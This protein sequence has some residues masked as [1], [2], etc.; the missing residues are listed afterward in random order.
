MEL[1]I[2]MARSETSA[3][4]APRGSRVVSQ[5][6]F[7]ALDA[8]PEA[9]QVAVAR[10]AQIMIRDQLKGRRENA[11]RAATKRSPAGLTHRAKP[12]ATA[13]RRAKAA[14]PKPARRTRRS[15]DAEPAA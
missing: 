1:S 9:Q 2:V 3:T 6:F 14:A 10:A 15:A 5:A 13:K 7:A 4:R 11:A 8:V 12:V